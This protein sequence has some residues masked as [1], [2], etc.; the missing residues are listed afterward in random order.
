MIEKDRHRRLPIGEMGLFALAACGSND[1]GTP[2]PAP[3]ASNEHITISV[4]DLN[5]PPEIITLPTLTLTEHETHE[6]ITLAPADVAT[7]ASV[8]F[9]ANLQI[10]PTLPAL[11]GGK[12]EFHLA[13]G[14]MKLV[15]PSLTIDFADSGIDTKTD[16]YSFTVH[17]SDGQFA[18]PVTIAVEIVHVD[19]EIDPSKFTGVPIVNG[20][21]TENTGEDGWFSLFIGDSFFD[22]SGKVDLN[23]VDIEKNAFFDSVTYSDGTIVVQNLPDGEILHVTI[24]YTSNGNTDKETISFFNDFD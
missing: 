1:T 10:D 9:F 15:D 17:V 23:K 22:P 11:D 8:L 16:L 3:A 2:A 20:T 19:P 21:I 5:M 13:S 7:D 14:V 12:L 6:T 4:N 18:V 24:S